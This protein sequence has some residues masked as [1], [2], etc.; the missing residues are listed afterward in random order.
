MPWSGLIFEHY[1][2]YTGPGNTYPLIL[3]KFHE[4]FH[5]NILPSLF[6]F[7]SDEPLSL[8]L[9]FSYLSSLVFFFFFFK[10]YLLKELFS[11]AICSFY[12][13]GFL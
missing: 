8:F 11:F 1:A 3:G 12:E 7:L 6:S 4:S 9:S 2:E 13:F 10:L 5:N